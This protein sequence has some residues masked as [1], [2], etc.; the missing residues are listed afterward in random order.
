L[1]D[2]LQA[3]GMLDD[4]LVVVL[5]EMGRTPKVN[6]RAGRD[7]WVGTYPAI[8]A[9]AGVKAGAVYGRSDQTG[10]DVAG[11]PVSPRDPRAKGDHLCDIDGSAQIA[12]QQRRPVSLY[13]E[14][15]PVRAI[16]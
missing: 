4:T 15:R 16:L 9:G 5:S 3:R 8:F 2:D 14:G 12:D 1:L 10:A 11:D 13:D 6:G 7:H